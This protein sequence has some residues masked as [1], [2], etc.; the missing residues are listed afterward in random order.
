LAAAVKTPY[1]R[2]EFISGTLKDHPLKSVIN[3]ENCKNSRLDV[4]EEKEI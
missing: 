3:P 4:I 2:S 1:T